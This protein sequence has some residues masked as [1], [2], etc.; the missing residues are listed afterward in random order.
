MSNRPLSYPFFSMD[1]LTDG[2]APGCGPERF[3]HE[4]KY[5]GFPPRE[6]E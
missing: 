1:Q 6:R 4:R 5:M 2:H 3:G